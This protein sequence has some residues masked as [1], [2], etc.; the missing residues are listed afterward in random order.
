MCTTFCFDLKCQLLLF[1]T[2]IK[3][4]NLQGRITNLL[5]LIHLGGAY[6]IYI[7]GVTKIAWLLLLPKPVI[8]FVIIRLYEESII[9]AT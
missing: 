6:S 4:K 8:Y 2:L 1:G 3:L 5:Q 9:L 7:W